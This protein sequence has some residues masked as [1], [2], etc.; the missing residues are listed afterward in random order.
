MPLGW[1]GFAVKAAFV[2]VFVGVILWIF[3]WIFTRGVE[4]QALKETKERLKREEDARAKE[5]SIQ[6]AARRVREAP[7]PIVPDLDELQ[8][9]ARGEADTPV[10]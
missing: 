5:K 6:E 3:R 7:G 4:K 2:L 9:R 1:V 8:R 10:T